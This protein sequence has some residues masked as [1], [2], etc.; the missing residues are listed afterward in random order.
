MS[1]RFTS[2]RVPASGIKELFA[3]EHRWAQ[4]LRVEAA[5][6][7]A[8]AEQGMIPAEAADAITAACR[9]EA[10]DLEEVR[11][12]RDRTS[13]PLMPLIVELSRVVGEPHGGW[14]HWGA[15]TQNITQTGDVLVLREAHHTIL[16][17][18]ARLL[19]ALAALA[20]KGAEMVMAGRTHGQH[21]VPVTFGFK[22]AAWIDELDRHVTRLRQLEPRL[23]QAIVGGAAGTFAAL[24]DEP[25]KLQADIARR[26]GLL[27]M[28]V[29]SRATADHFAEF[30]CALG[31][32]A[33]TG[34]KIARE[35]YTLMKTEYQ[36]VEEPVPAGTIGSSTMP[37]KRN[38]QLCQDVLGLTAEIRSLV[39]LALEHLH[40]EHEA[41]HAPSDLF[42]A[43]ER[44]CVLTGDALERLVVILSGLRV[45]PER[46]RAN[47]DLSGGMISAEAIMLRLGTRI[48]RQHAHDVV[49]EASQKAATGGGSFP[50]LLAAD[51]RVT[52]HL[53][54][55]DITTLLDPATHT[56]R[57]ASLARTGARRARAAAADLRERPAS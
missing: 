13:H 43:Q 50:G 27:P 19:D 1:Q 25:E 2:G 51:P 34:G 53:S 47:L 46:M 33:G 39:P 17:Q 54:A 18:L 4:W 32:L 15:T 8:Q 29:P 21:A 37:Q 31:L 42:A 28:A 26:L 55:D 52:A 36:E 16:T 41:D 56:G 35:V 49:Y 12:E 38:P 9:P 24:G 45:A 48:G 6:A 20:E 57:S 40:N 23:C 30:V 10:L 7:Q 22:V 44:A 11:R 5:L 14:V 3:T